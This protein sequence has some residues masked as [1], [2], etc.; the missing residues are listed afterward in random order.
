MSREIENKAIVGRWFKGFWANPWNPKIIDEL[1][2]PD[3][4]LQYSLHSP[5]RGREDVRNFIMGFREA[6]P[7][8]NFWVLPTSSPK[9]TMWLAV[10]RVAARTPDPPLATFSPAPFRRRP[11][12]RCGLP[13][14]LY[15]GSRTPKLPKKSA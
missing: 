10:G 8:L 3:M 14:R 13:E 9:A 5:R 1:A 4:L 6:F 11:A 2:T 7:D 12:G 15:S